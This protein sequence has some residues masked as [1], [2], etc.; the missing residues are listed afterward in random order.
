F[1]ALAA[2]ARATG[3]LLSGYRETTRQLGD[4][5]IQQEALL[6]E[7][8]AAEEKYLLYVNK[9]EETRI[10]DALDRGGMLNVTIAEQPTVPVLPARSGWSFG[11]LGILVAGAL[12]TSL[13]F[14]AD[15]LNPAFR[16]PD[17]VI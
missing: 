16:T 15:Y 8:K 2:R 13:A 1:S 10:G 12:S 5:A 3:I 7:L 17:E 9:R 14:A 11:L 6:H 4:R